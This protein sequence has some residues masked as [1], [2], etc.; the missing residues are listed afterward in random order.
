[1]RGAAVQALASNYKDDADTKAI[2][3]TRATADDHSYVRRA[4]VQALAS[5]FKD[6]KDTLPILKESATA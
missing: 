5:N 3:K 1:M 4:A 2:L 6:D